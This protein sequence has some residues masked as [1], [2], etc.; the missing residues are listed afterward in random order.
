MGLFTVNKQTPQ[1]LSPR[2]LR[3]SIFLNGY[4]YQL[5]HRAGKLMGNADALS[6]L[7][8]ESPGED[9]SPAHCILAIEALP[10]TPL[11]ARDIAEGS[12]KDP[13][14]SRVLNWVWK[15]W[16]AR[17]EGEVFAPFFIRQTE[18]SAH[19]GCLLWGHCVVIP[20]KLQS[21]V[22]KALHVGHPGMIHMKA[23]ARSYVW[24]PGIDKQV[25]AWVRGCAT[26]QADR[27]DVPSAPIHPWEPTK[28][29]WSR[30]HMDFAGPFHGQVFLIVVDA[31]SKWLEVVPV[32]TMTTRTVIRALSR[33]FATHGLPDTLVSDNGAQFVSAEFKEFTD[34]LLIRHVTSAPFHP[35]TNGQAE[36]MVR[37][38][39]ESLKK[40]VNGDWHQKVWEFLARQ[41]S[42]PSSVTG[43]SPAE[44]LMGRKLTTV[45]DR[46]HPDK[47]AGQP[48]V[49]PAST[50]GF[51][52]GAWVF[53]RNY[54]GG[55]RWVAATVVKATGPLSYL[56][57]LEGGQII[58]RHIDQVRE[59]GPSNGESQEE[60]F[61]MPERETG[62]RDA[63]ELS[64]Q[65]EELQA[66]P[67]QPASSAETEPSLAVP[68]APAPPAAL[69][70]GV[71]EPVGQSTPPPVL[72]RS[73]RV[74]AT[75]KYLEDYI[76]H[77]VV[78]HLGGEGCSVCAESLHPSNQ[79]PVKE[80]E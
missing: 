62:T 23:L 75:P 34:S 14:L 46:L 61:R 20:W 80:R 44:L 76:H 25:E 38:T 56:V 54:S 8:L 57:K 71:P 26:C 24:W 3:W 69:P 52:V 78:Y 53:V 19:K 7:P 4:S 10:D 37:F 27:P 28:T 79:Q 12:R 51:V 18:L 41:H 73:A 55:S 67:E 47:L 64:D 68:E 43:H 31:Y 65:E 1:I 29:P 35:A 16:P 45:L 48:K 50:R 70:E 9:P 74:R 2:M 40:L 32:T 17:G 77:L 13:V 60:T 5:L 72:R 15:G 22:L 49:K 63:P 33:L 36:R 39:K 6:R 21:C 42:T 59:R 66:S 58:L 11:S 30:V